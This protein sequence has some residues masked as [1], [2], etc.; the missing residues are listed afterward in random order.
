MREQINDDI[1]TWHCYLRMRKC[2][3]IL[4]CKSKC[5]HI[6]ISQDFINFNCSIMKLLNLEALKFK[7]IH[8]LNMNQSKST[9]YQ[10]NLTDST[11]K[12]FFPLIQLVIINWFN[13]EIYFLT[14]E[15][16]KRQ[17]TDSISKNLTDS[18][19]ESKYLFASLLKQI[20]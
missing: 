7:N 16:V 2:I 6:F 3:N 19:L 11:V 13:S 18:D 12:I 10:W 14:G 1:L 20:Y 5:N 4:T 9:D 15:S 8:S 17:N